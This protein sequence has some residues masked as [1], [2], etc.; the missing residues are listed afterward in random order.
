MTKIF[1]LAISTIITIGLNAQDRKSIGNFSLFQQ[2]YNPGLTGYEGSIVKVFHRNQWSG[3]DGAPKTYFVSAELDPADLGAWK[4]NNVLKSTGD[5]SYD[6]QKGAKHAFGLLF[7]K[8]TFGPFV[9][10][11][12]SLSY[13]SRIQLTEKISL[14]AG[15]AI[16]YEIQ[17]LDGHKLSPEQ[18]ND[19]SIQQYM[20]QANNSGKFDINIGLMATADH[21]YAGYA[22]KD[23][24]KGKLIK[25]G[26]DPMED[27]YRFQH[28]IQ[29]GYRTA[30]SDHFGLIV[31]GLFQYD[32]RINETLEGQVKGIFHNVFWVGA[33]YRHDLALTMNTG[34][35]FHQFRIGYAY[36]TPIGKAQFMNS[37][38]NE[39][40]ITY[41]IIPVKY[42]KLSRV[43]SMW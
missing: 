42:P 15:A 9:D 38:T 6:R 2:Y 8:D 34:F 5:D 12:I 4:K 41:N 22:L 40:M 39:L 10:N 32:E 30:L 35:R 1:I 17:R 16:T 11:Q 37:A 27:T 31:N 36:E 14:R 20:N 29:A 7:F 3:F 13:G 19:P 28:I 25:S 24:M 21:F 23:A 26:V 33:G 18:L 43:V